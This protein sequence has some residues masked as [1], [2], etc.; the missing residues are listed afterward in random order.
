MTGGH[1]APGVTEAEFAVLVRRAGLALDEPARRVLHEVYGHL[2]RMVERNRTPIAG[3]DRP[4][5]A[6]P[7]TVFVP[8]QDWPVP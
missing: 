3:G 6:E 4:R 8:G 5:G 1:P 2:E 7:A